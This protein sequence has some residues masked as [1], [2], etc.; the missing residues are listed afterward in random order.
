MNNI[1]YINPVWVAKNTLTDISSFSIHDLYEMYNNFTKSLHANKV[2]FE[3][4]IIDGIGYTRKE[5]NNK[6]VVEDNIRVISSLNVISLD[7]KE[8]VNSLKGNSTYWKQGDHKYLS[9]G[10][11]HVAL[12]SPSFNDFK[13]LVEISEMNATKDVSVEDFVTKDDDLEYLEMD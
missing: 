3:N 5:K 1:W 4:K 6:G 7:M 10:F 13:T 9:Y 2:T 12:F 11:Y 8:K